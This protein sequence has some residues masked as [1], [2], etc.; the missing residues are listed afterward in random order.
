M[1]QLVPGQPV[2]RLPAKRRK[3]QKRLR[4]GKYET[5]VRAYPGQWV[6]LKV[7]DVS[8]VRIDS[9]QAWV[10]RTKAKIA[11]RSVNGQTVIL[12]KMPLSREAALTDSKN[13]HPAQAT[14]MDLIP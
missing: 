8:N 7:S 9:K 2:K 5:M 10:K 14:Y 13:R 11:R 4:L 6:V 12:G 3:T 1:N